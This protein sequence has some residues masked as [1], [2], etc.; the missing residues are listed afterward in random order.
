MKSVSQKNNLFGVTRLVL[1]ANR[2]IYMEQSQD[3]MLVSQPML[4]EEKVA[5]INYR[6]YDSVQYD[7]G[8]TV[9]WWEPVEK[10]RGRIREMWGWVK[11]VDTAYKV[12][13]LVNDEQSIWIDLAMIVDVNVA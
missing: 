7:Y 1:T 4:A 8:V 13:K 12:I 6:I 3:E 2:D 9:R 10:G 5:E 11:D